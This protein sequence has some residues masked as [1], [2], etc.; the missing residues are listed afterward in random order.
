MLHEV[1]IDCVVLFYH[2][3]LISNNPNMYEQS[4]SFLD[5]FARTFLRVTYFKGQKFGSVYYCPY[6][7]PKSQ[8]FK[9]LFTNHKNL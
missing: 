6:T 5:L 9:Q 2:H 3:F 7:S 1:E 4:I 8:S